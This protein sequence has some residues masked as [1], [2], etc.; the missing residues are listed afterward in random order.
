MNVG[1]VDLN[2]DERDVNVPIILRQSDRL[3]ANRLS[4][5]LRKMIISGE[6]TL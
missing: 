1:S 5:K 4:Q 2:I 6:F 3:R